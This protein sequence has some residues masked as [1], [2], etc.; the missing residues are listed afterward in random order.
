MTKRTR[1]LL[2]LLGI[3]LKT[4]GTPSHRHDWL[5]RPLIQDSRPDLLIRRKWMQ[6][7]RK[8][9]VNGFGDPE[10]IGQI[11]GQSPVG[12]GEESIRE[13]M[14]GLTDFILPLL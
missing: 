1:K 8:I 2:I 13:R 5:R 11:T 6:R 12:Q 4:D 9:P 14:R 3:W 7:I 10:E